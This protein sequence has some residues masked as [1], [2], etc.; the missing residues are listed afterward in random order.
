VLSRY[1]RV[2]LDL[3]FLDKN[4]KI[5]PDMKLLLE[6]TD[7][8]L[9]YDSPSVVIGASEAFLLFRQESYYY[10]SILSLLSFKYNPFQIALLQLS[11]LLEFAHRS[12]ELFSTI[13][14]YFYINYNENRELIVKKLEILAAVA[15]EPNAPNI[16]K[17]LSNYTRHES[18]EISALA[19]STLGKICE[20]QPGLVIPCTKHLIS[21]LKSKAPYITAQVII[22]MRTLINQDPQK[23][24]KII[25]HCAKTIDSIHYPTA[26]ACALW[27]IGK[28]YHIIPTLSIETMRK[29]SLTFLR[30]STPVKHQLLN[31]TA[32]I[33]SETANEKL[34]F[35]LKYLLE[36]GFYDLSYDIRDKCRLLN[37][38]FITKELPLSKLQILESSDIIVSSKQ[39]IAAFAPMSLSYLLGS[40]VAGYERYWEHLFDKVQIEKTIKE[41]TSY[42]RDEEVIP[43]VTVK[44]AMSYSSQEVSSSIGGS[45]LRARVVVNDPAKF[46]AFLQDSGNEEDDEEEEEYEEGEDEEEEEEEEKDHNE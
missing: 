33:Y 17:E 1:A 24:R 31:S 4:A 20:K 29:L 35:V 42:I 21:L 9:C 43:T 7:S 28:Y 10:K 3:Q 6:N 46:Q 13:Y 19:I 27:I 41:D 30:E 45:G 44:A 40:R 16:L 11:L 15:S 34:G 23:H 38:I 8:L 37:S 12:P 5:H 32:K 2:Y 14:Q 39:E 25:V 18:P 22:V 36:L 26:R